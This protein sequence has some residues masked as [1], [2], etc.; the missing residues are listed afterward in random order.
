MCPVISLY[1]ITQ[2]IR[3]LASRPE[4]S[5][6]SCRVLSLP[7]FLHWKRNTNH[8]REWFST[9]P[10]CVRCLTWPLR[11]AHKPGKISLVYSS[12]SVEPLSR[13]A[14]L[15][16]TPRDGPWPL[17][18]SAFSWVLWQHGMEY[19]KRH[20]KPRAKSKSSM[21]FYLTKQQCTTAL[22]QL[23]VDWKG[24]AWIHGILG[25]TQ[26]YKARGQEGGSALK[27]NT[28][29]CSVSFK[30]PTLLVNFTTF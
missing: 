30:V 8:V 17:R 16:H 23:C 12:I 20:M 10:H 4:L 11:S 25:V 26:V 2:S 18:C 28:V 13:P 6:P 7:R 19:L 15:T 24:S 5:V 21:L 1:T 22:R 9:H 27:A 29:T 14:L 3:H